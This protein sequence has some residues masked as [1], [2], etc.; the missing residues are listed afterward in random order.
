MEGGKGRKEELESGE[1]EE[2]GRE[3]E[4]KGRAHL[5]GKQAAKQQE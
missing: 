1:G 5:R 4:E 2:E 3:F